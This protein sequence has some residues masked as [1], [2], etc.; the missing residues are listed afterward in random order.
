M[1]TAKWTPSGKE[2]WEE[3][4]IV[5][6][7]WSGTE[8]QAARQLQFT[9]PWNPYDNNFKNPKVGLGDRIK[10][11]NGTK[12][13]FAGIITNREKTGAIGTA[14]F[15]AYDNMHYLL[16]QT[17]T[18]KFKSTTPKKITTSLC[19]QLGLK[20]GKIQDPK[21]NITNLIYRDQSVYDIIVNAYR[22][23]YEKNGV[24]YMPV[25]SGTKLSIIKKGADS[26]VT[27][28]QTV[29]I[30]DA[31]YHDTTDNMINYVAIYDK[32]NKEV[33]CQKNEKNIKK[34]GI[35]M[36]AYTLGEKQTV[37]EAKNKAERLLVGITKEASVEALGNVACTAGKSIQIRDKA[38]GIVGK[39]YITS[40]SHSFHDGIHTMKLELSQKNVMETGAKAEK[41]K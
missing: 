4:P 33:A 8:N 6:C 1:I 41:I 3:L 36:G 28:D 24:K 12:L 9:I 10:L 31:N 2:K 7:E 40:D 20:V 19:K 32:S 15:S 35:Y 27:L 29:D 11:Y 23:A 26:G 25:M 14:S 34:Y 39:F 22:R 30:L 5:S 21:T 16:R 17:V 37:A 38:T 13:L 18:R